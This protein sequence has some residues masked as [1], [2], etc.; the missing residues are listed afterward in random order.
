[1]VLTFPMPSAPRPVDTNW[2]GSFHRGAAADIWPS[3]TRIHGAASGPA[4]CDTIFF[5][6]ALRR[7]EPLCRLNVA[8]WEALFLPEAGNLPE[9]GRPPGDAADPGPPGTPIPEGPKPGAPAGG[10]TP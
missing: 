2:L 3:G 7:S 5:A 6:G 8:G 1:M 10:P 9:S 4:S